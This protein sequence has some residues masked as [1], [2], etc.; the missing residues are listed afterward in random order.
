[1][2]PIPPANPNS[3][4]MSEASFG[5]SD[6]NSDYVESTKNSPMSSANTPDLDGYI[7]ELEMVHEVSE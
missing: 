3:D 2:P 5:E 7:S 1:M 6:G 4:V